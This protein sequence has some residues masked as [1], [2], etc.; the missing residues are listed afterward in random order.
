MTTPSRRAIDC[1]TGNL[2]RNIW[3]LSWPTAASSALLQI[4]SILDGIWLGRLGAEALAGAGIGMALR[5][6]LIS[7][8]MALSAAAGAVVARYVGAKEMARANRAV[9]QAVMLFAATAGLIG[10]LGLAL[11]TPLIKLAGGTGSVLPLAVR[12]AQILFIGLIAMEM[13]PSVGYMLVAAGSPQLSLRV[14]LLGGIVTLVAEPILVLG[15][16]NWRGLGVPGGALALVLGNVCAMIYALYLLFTR[17]APVWIDTNDLVVDWEMIKRIVRIA[18][19][20]VI[21]RGTPNLAQSILIRIISS[22]GATTLAAYNIAMRVINLAN[23][24]S[25][26]TA[27]SSGALVGQNL[28]AHQPQ[29]AERGTFT[30]AAIAVI[31]SACLVGLTVFLG[32]GILGFFSA[33]AEVLDKGVHVLRIVGVGQFLYTTSLAF[34]NGLAGAGDTLSPM[35][36]NTI[37]LWAIQL[38]AIY[39]LSRGLGWGSE[40]I[41][42]AIVISQ[43]GLVLM[44][45]ARFR[46]GHWK[47][48]EI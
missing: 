2:L 10:L 21:Q 46:Q 31:L 40:G 5:V 7:P 12:Y 8:L 22:Y 42:W 44:L 29:R 48:Q 20:A 47:R 36:L 34:D 26:G 16:G 35:I 9:L 45:S 11:T 41:W 24:P 27:R 37:M 43:A 23:I 14:N 1:T 3:D 25:W 33:D 15:L 6:T 19:P 39:L 13:V 18:L 38:P 30:V 17:Q 28:G 32:R 4:P